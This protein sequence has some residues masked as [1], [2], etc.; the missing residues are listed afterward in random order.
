MLAGMMTILMMMQTQAP[1]PPP[2]V[3]AGRPVNSVEQAK[4]MPRTGD[5]VVLG[6]IGAADANMIEASTLAGT[7][8]STAAVKS[9]AAGVLKD[10][11]KSLTDGANLAKALNVT[12]V[13]PADTAMARAQKRAMDNLNLLSGAAFDRAYVRYTVDAH[14]ALLKKD[15]AAL[16]AKAERPEVKMFLADRQKMLRM[17]DENGEKLIKK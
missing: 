3:T 1:T 7:K 13:L 10:H 12:R 2:A 11:Q 9:Y 6:T 17:H 15:V 16:P 5:A 4:V 8:A 14:D